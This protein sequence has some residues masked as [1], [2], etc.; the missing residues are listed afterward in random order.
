MKIKALTSFAGIDFSMAP[1]EV[2]DLPE[3]IAEDLIN[4]GF[5]TRDS[6]ERS[7]FGDAMP[8]EDTDE[9]KR[10]DTAGDIKPAK[11]RGKRTK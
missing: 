6:V 7:L 4:A 3:A 8:K 5:A 9:S 11:G 1:G 2:Q 10:V